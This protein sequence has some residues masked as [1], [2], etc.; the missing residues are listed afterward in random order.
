MKYLVKQ[1]AVNTSKWQDCFDLDIMNWQY[2][3]DVCAA[4]GQHLNNIGWYSSD[5]DSNTNQWSSSVADSVASFQPQGTEFTATR[6]IGSRRWTTHVGKELHNQ[7]I[8]PA[9]PGTHGNNWVSSLITAATD[10]EGQNYDK[11]E[12][13]Y[14]CCIPS[15]RGEGSTMDT[16][17]C[18][19]DFHSYPWE[20]RPWHDWVMVEWETNSG[21]KYKHAAKL[22]LWAPFIDTVTGDSEIRCAIQSLQS[23][24]PKPDS[25]L[26]FFIGDK[27]DCRVRVIPACMILETA[28]VL[29]TVATADDEFP[30]STDK[31]DYF[32]IVPPRSEWAKIGMDLG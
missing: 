23:N 4:A 24:N 5:H 6:Q 16:L 30:E 18:H 15:A 17:R 19:P 1:Q 7:A 22:L 10:A 12:F 9:T 3:S 21:R 11:I 25:L 26:P 13:F 28:Y 31:A 32:V 27:I 20:R 2:E 14:A 29:P 8:Y